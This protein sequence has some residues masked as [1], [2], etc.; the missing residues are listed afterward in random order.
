MRKLLCIIS[1]VLCTGLLSQA[2]N[3]R[4][5]YGLEWGYTA[6]FYKASQHNFI[7]SEGYRII[8]NPDNRSFF[9]NGTVLANV[10]MDLNSVLNA[11]FHTGLIGVYSRRWMVPLELRATCC[12]SGLHADGALFQAGTAL[13][14]P[15]TE[16]YTPA[17]GARLGGG[18]RLAVYRNFSVDLLLSFTFTLDHESITDPDTLQSVPA[19][20]IKRNSS[21]YYGLN[22]SLAVNF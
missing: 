9:S 21:E 7:C 2:F 8:E 20:D 10:G 13:L 1:F 12:P 15:T 6:T 17:F 18:Y 14:I 3:P 19:A 4:L 11:S 5:S 22:L 16:L